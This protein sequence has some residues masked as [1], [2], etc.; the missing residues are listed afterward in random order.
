MFEIL[1]F[2]TL[3]LVAILIAARYMTGD[4]RRKKIL[5]VTA[6]ILSLVISV[7]AMVAYYPPEQPGILL[8]GIGATY[9]IY[10]VLTRFEQI[11]R[12][13]GTLYRTFEITMSL[14]ELSTF[15]T[16]Q[17]FIVNMIFAAVTLLLLETTRR[18]LEA[19][20][21]RNNIEGMGLQRKTSLEG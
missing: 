5:L 14:L 2:F 7:F 11:L 17:L 9:V 16:P 4:S 21:S 13:G 18:K 3:F 20:T 15:R 12:W 1:W 10:R 6:P 8:A 19:K